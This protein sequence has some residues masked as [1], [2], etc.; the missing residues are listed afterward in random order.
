MQQVLLG[1]KLFTTR[2]SSSGRNISAQVIVSSG[3]A[4]NIVSTA[5]HTV[6]GPPSVRVRHKVALNPVSGQLEQTVN[7]HQ[8]PRNTMLAT[9]FD[10]F[11]A[12]D[13]SDHCRQGTLA[14]ETNWSTKK[15]HL[16]V[17]S[18]VFGI[19]VTNALL[20]YKYEIAEDDK[21]ELRELLGQL[22]HELTSNTFLRTDRDTRLG[23][24]EQVQL[25]S[26]S[27]SQNYQ[28]TVTL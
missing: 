12:V 17:L 6:P 22:A 23:N 5:G 3:W 20:A 11:S 13:I 28:L 16:R 4:D 26:F 9:F 15:Y 21:M 1:S 18:S 10:A 7:T 25:L 27:I 8:I 19:R 2:F 24:E 14:M